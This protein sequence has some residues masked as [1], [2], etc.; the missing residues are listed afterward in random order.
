MIQLG[1]GHFA[2]YASLLGDGKLILVGIFDLIW[3]NG[4]EPVRMPDCWLVFRLTGSVADGT[5]HEFMM[6]V[7]DEDGDDMVAALQA[8]NLLP[9]ED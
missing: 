4:T 6:R 1:F 7:V 8:K 2:D 5:E 3:S 9:A